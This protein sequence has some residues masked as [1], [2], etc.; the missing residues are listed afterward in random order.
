MLLQGK[1]GE[2]NE[3][4]L[5]LTIHEYNS[6]RK[7]DKVDSI[8]DRHMNAVDLSPKLEKFQDHNK[9]EALY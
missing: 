8:Q 2:F 5:Q 6:K 1:T 7:L 4:L 3:S 9:E